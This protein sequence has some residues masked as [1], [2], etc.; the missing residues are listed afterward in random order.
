MNS[1]K[2]IKWLAAWGPGIN[3][4]PI[5]LWLRKKSE[6]I[7]PN[8]TNF[9][10]CSNEG[11]GCS[12]PSQSHLVYSGPIQ[13]TTIKCHTLDSSTSHWNINGLYHKIGKGKT[14]DDDGG[15]LRRYSIGGQGQNPEHW[16]RAGL[17]DQH[18]FHRTEEGRKNSCVLVFISLV[19]SEE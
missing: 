15:K 16:W 12:K 14:E 19:K 9:L 1:S 8:L 6:I 5:Q 10:L 2:P 11:W 18:R 3:Y 4:W 13:S 17:R 7:Q